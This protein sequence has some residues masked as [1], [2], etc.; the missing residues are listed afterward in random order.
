MPDPKNKQN[1]LKGKEALQTLDDSHIIA[2]FHTAFITIKS[3]TIISVPLH[4]APTAFTCIAVNTFPDFSSGY[5]HLISC[6]SIRDVG[7]VDRHAHRKLDNGNPIRQ[8]RGRKV[9]C[10][11]MFLIFFLTTWEWSVHGFLV[12]GALSN[13]GFGSCLPHVN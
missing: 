10:H 7:I 8:C 13:R 1:K 6:F 9:V 3:S 2:T 5:P 11:F 4:A 12:T